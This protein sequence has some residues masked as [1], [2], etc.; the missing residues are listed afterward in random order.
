M[1]SSA[2]TILRIKRKRNEEP[3]DALVVESRVRRK[4]SRGGMDVFQFAQTIEDD[5]WKDEKC[6]KDLEAQISR[7]TRE[8]SKPTK[9]QQVEK[10]MSPISRQQSED[11]RRRYTVELDD[12]GGRPLKRPPT[13]ISEKEAAKT[14]FKV[15]DAVPSP[16]KSRPPADTESEIDKFIPLLN[17]YLS[18]HDIS[19]SS[20]QQPKKKEEPKSSPGVA[21][22]STKV[23]DDY[24]DY[25][26]DVFFR[27]PGAGGLL[28]GNGNI[29][30]LTGLPPVDDEL[31]GSSSES[32][33][34]DEADEDSNAEEYYKNDYPDEEEEDYSS[35]T[36]DEF[37]EDSDFQDLIDD[38][39]DWD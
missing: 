34:E 5:D 18:L 32:E 24:V 37:H 1:Q 25:V 2:Y 16:E 38:G 6:K 7:L 20:T 28:D 9:A 31:Y 29:A 27:R 13:V 19:P 15:Y 14:N 33:F 39:N 10:T 30:T 23:Y 8:V 12:S 4:K 11:A 36:S 35:G 22:K 26:W 21:F 3:L 17:E